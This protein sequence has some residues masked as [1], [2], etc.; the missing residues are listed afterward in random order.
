MSIP[1]L[2]H[3]LRCHDGDSPALAL[4]NG[5][6]EEYRWSYARLLNTA[7]GFRRVLEASGAGAGSTICVIAGNSPQFVALFLACV[8]LGAAFAPLHRDQG[9]A[10]LEDI[11]AGLDAALVIVDEDVQGT[12]LS[13]VLRASGRVWRLRLCRTPWLRPVLSG[14][15][16]NAARGCN[17]KGRPAPVRIS[18][19]FMS[20]ELCGRTLATLNVSNANSGGV[21][22]NNV[23]KVDERA[24]VAAG[25]TAPR[26]DSA[27]V[28]ILH[29]SGS[30]GAPKVIQY[31]RW[32]LNVFLHWQGRLFTAFPDLPPGCA[33]SPRVN[34]LPMTHFGG[35]SFVLQALL[36]GRLVHL[37]RAIAPRDY[38]MLA[39]RERC[40]LLMFV[41]ALYEALVGDAIGDLPSS[42][43]R[44]CLTM[45]EGVTPR[46]IALVTRALRVRVYSAY[47]MSEGLSGLSHHGDDTP[48]DSCGRLLFGEAKL[49]DGAMHDAA[50]AE[51]GA[52]THGAGDGAMSASNG[53]I[54]AGNEAT[55]AKNEATSEGE[56]WVRND[57]TFPCY[58]DAALNAAKFVDGWYRTG[59]RFRRDAAGHH[60]FL[61]RVDAMCVV[62]GRNLYPVDVERVFLRHRDVADCMAALLTLDKGRRRL[63]VLVCLRPGS[64]ATSATLID[65]YVEHGA[66]HATPAWLVLGKGIPRNAAGKRD[67]LAV[68]AILEED[69]RRCLRKVS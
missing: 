18:P 6:A 57:T 59:D 11:L 35:L 1:D 52:A 49:V 42:S 58:C 16:C 48:S 61:G 10:A 56:L 53:A 43:L 20:R 24:C 3:V 30:T 68:A 67:R 65:W 66:L 21:F 63:G 23:A 17:G 22:V 40:Q 39:M 54:S 37:P 2:L 28:L 31:S 12:M 13:A 45:G 60:Y 55:S 25:D 4:L 47:G 64:L 19:E 32:R 33:P 46:L 14:A 50:P 41:P 34:A 26:E 15:G 38:L 62:N 7:L 51:A 8:D 29:S 44:Y 5:L 69:Y 9:S 27:P 36:D